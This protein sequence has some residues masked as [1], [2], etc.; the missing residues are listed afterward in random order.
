[1]DMDFRESPRPQSHQ[2]EASESQHLPSKKKSGKGKKFLLWLMVLLLIAGAG[3]AG[4]YYRDLQAKDDEKVYK[5]EIATL[6]AKNDSLEKE[7]TVTIRA[8]GNPT[9]SAC[10]SGCG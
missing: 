10:E 4:W 2:S 8:M 1:M 9:P 7:L 6:K 3:A 5:A